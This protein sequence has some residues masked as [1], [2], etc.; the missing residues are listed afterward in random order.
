MG[1]LDIQSLL[2]PKNLA[3][4]AGAAAVGYFLFKRK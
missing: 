3:M 2:A 4:I 1:A